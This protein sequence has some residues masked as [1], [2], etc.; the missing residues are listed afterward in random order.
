[1]TDTDKDKAMFNRIAQE[2]A[3]QE[4]RPGTRIMRRFQLLNALQSVLQVK[5]QLGHVLDIGCGFATPAQYLLGLYQSYTGVDHSAEMV[6][7]GQDIHRNNT[8]VRL[9]LADVLEADLPVASF[10][11]VLSIKSLHHFPDAEA[12]LERLK[13]LTRNGAHLVIIEPNSRNHLHSFMQWVRTI[14]KK[15]E[16]NPAHKQHHFKK[17]EL[18]T[19]LR[20]NDFEILDCRERGYFTQL[21]RIELPWH[22]LSVCLAHLTLL[23][24]RCCDRFMPPFLRFLS[25]HIVLQARFPKKHTY[26]TVQEI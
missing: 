12:V 5:Q 4:M 16:P 18:E 22:T 1:M 21:N 10:D 26:E 8:N 9:I 6:Q 25:S 14:W 15:S 19:L 11:L 23:L 7:L 2:Y 20:K 17:E 3:R 24:D 13:V